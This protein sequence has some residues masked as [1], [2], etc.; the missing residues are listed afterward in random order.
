MRVNGISSAV[1]TRAAAKTSASEAKSVN[2]GNSKQIF[3]LIA[4]K[5]LQIIEQKVFSISRR[6][7]VFGGVCEQFLEL[8]PL[9]IF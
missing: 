8:Y 4:A 2:E 1:S 9:V 6:K 5:I 3:L 7:A